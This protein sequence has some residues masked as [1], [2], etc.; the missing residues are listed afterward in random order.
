MALGKISCYSD[1]VEI[2]ISLIDFLCYDY[3]R[4]LYRVSG[5]RGIQIVCSCSTTTQKEGVPMRTILTALFIVSL[6]CATI[7]GGVALGE[8]KNLS[9]DKGATAKIKALDKK[10]FK[11]FDVYSAG[12]TEAP[13]ALLF[14]Q[15]DKYHLPSPLWGK[16]LSEQQIIYAIDRLDKQYEDKHWDISFPPRALN[17]VNSKGRV[18][19]FVHTGLNTILMDVKKDGNVTV[20]LPS[21]EARGGGGGGGGGGGQ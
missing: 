9:V 16:P 10:F 11:K 21:A 17:V 13:M 5:K 6:V 14:D 2:S 7:L 15:K 18:L 3:V 1:P 19:G 20:Y 8:V 12:V 4:F